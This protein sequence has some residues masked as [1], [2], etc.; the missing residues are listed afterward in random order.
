MLLIPED[1]LKPLKTLHGM[2]PACLTLSVQPQPPGGNVDT[3]PE[4]SAEQ[5]T[6]AA[7]TTPAGSDSTAPTPA[8]D[9]DAGASE[10]QVN[11]L[12]TAVQVRCAAIQSTA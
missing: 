7:E 12:V 9:A 5:E 10:P 11:V 1:F 8:D 6:A 3:V 2:V 4:E